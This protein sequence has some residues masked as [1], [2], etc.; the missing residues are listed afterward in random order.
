[1]QLSKEARDTLTRLV[2]RT[3]YLIGQLDGD[4]L[5]ALT[6]DSPYVQF[7]SG[8]PYCQAQVPRAIANE[9]LEDGLITPIFDPTKPANQ[10]FRITEKGRNC[11]VNGIACSA[12]GSEA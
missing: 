8:G 4:A 10:V 9:L 7:N 12:D 5:F 3:A 6:S 2:A 11:L 1:M